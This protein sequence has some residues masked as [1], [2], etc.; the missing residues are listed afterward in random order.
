MT[1][2]N[3]YATRTRQLQSPGLHKRTSS[4]IS[5]CLKKHDQEANIT[6]KDLKYMGTVLLSRL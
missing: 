5:E 1:F 2:K 4:L 6:L 3:K